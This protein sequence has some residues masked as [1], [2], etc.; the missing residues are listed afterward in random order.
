MSRPLNATERIVLLPLVEHR[1]A[2]R[3]E[4]AAT[5]RGIRAC[6]RLLAGTDGEATLDL[7]TWTLSTPRTPEDAAREIER[8]W[9]HERRW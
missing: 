9:S 8:S 5:E 3:R 2:L 7:D 4:L 6:V 1:A